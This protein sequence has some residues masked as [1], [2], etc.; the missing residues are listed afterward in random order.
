MP[1]Y[2]VETYLARGDAAGRAARER[3]ARSAAEELTREGTRVRFDRSH[4]RSRGRDLLLRLRRAVGP[5]RRARSQSGPGSTRC[6]S[7]RRS[8]PERS[9]DHENPNRIRCD[10]CARRRPRPGA[11]GNVSGTGDRRARTPSSTGAASPRGRSPPAVRPRAAPCSAAMVHGAMYDAVAAVEGG[12]EPFA[13]GVTAPPDASADAA[14]AQAARDVLVARV[15]GQAATVQIAY[16]TYMASIPDG[17]AKDARQGRRRGRRRRHARDADRRPLRRR[18]SVRPA[19]AGARACSS[20]SRRRRRSTSSSA[21][22]AAVHVRLAVRLP[23]GRPVR[24][25]E[26]AL[27]ARTWPSCR[28]IG[29]RRQRRGRRADRD[30]PLL[31]R[32]DLRP[33]QPRPARAGER[34]RPRPARVGPAAGLRLASRPRTR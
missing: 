4:P 33:V 18:R 27:R 12:L 15:P 10:A 29:R 6:A 31:H 5:R 13:T 14:V 23:A 16:D 2:L 11:D 1:S 8:R 17:P 22:R 9:T 3:R 34:A 30:G 7:S 19:D 20:R 21:V 28:R 25:D 26:Q 24:A 32:P